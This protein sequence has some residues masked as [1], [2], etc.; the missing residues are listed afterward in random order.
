MAERLQTTERLKSIPEYQFTNNFIAYQESVVAA[1]RFQ[2]THEQII[3]ELAQNPPSAIAILSASVLATPQ[4]YVPTEYYKTQPDF[5]GSNTGVGGG[6]TRVEA[7]ATLISDP[8]FTT[9]DHTTPIITLSTSADNHSGESDAAIYGRAVEKIGVTNPVIEIPWST[10]TFTETLAILATAIERDMSHIVVITNYFQVE[11]AKVMFDYWQRLAEP[12]IYEQI[13]EY[14]ARL[15]ARNTKRY[16]ALSTLEADLDCGFATLLAFHEDL[17]GLRI[18]IYADEDIVDNPEPFLN[19]RA[20]AQHT[21]NC[22]GVD[23][24][25]NGDYYLHN[26]K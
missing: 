24:F 6:Q 10:D 8:A 26:G 19:E 21:L 14:M 4:G 15:R 1:E 23:D 20:I 5:A 18:S 9:I 22:H 17:S 7:A 2:L 25:L 12:A 11:R 3:Q 13:A 16:P